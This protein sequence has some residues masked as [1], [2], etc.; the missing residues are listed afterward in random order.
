M[1][2]V[3]LLAKVIAKKGKE[4]AVEAFLEQAV[5]IAQ[6]EQKTITWYAFKMNESTFGI[7]DTFE[8][9]DARNAHLNGDIPALLIQN[10]S[11]LLAVAP[12]IKQIE[13]LAV[14]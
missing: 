10:S 11:E 7:F 6:A 4:N 3:G 13:I 2:K 5:N 12:E 1:I 14:K 9:E 8:G